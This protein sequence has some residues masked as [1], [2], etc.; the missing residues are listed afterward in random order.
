MTEKKKV[1]ISYSHK[2]SDVASK[3]YM[4]LQE[5]GFDVWLDVHRL[6]PGQSLSGQ[7]DSG[8]KDSDY[9]VLSHQ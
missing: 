7:I 6:I 1:F 9:Y 2:D 8:L 4:G 5:K 3:I